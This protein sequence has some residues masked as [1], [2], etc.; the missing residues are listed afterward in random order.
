[1]VRA[2]QDTVNKH[3]RKWDDHKAKLD[4]ASM[5]C[6]AAFC[7]LDEGALSKHHCHLWEKLELF[8][9]W[10][11]EAKRKYNKAVCEL[12]NEKQQQR[13]RRIWE[14]LEWY[15]NGQPVIDLNVNWQGSWCDCSD[16]TA[17]IWRLNTTAMDDTLQTL[18]SHVAN[19]PFKTSSLSR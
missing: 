3:K 8:Q 12:R 5:A 13:N 10:M 1:V 14:N 18:P 19:A 7:N 4:H 15:Q 9:D 6:Q 16:M 11:M 17:H 2:R